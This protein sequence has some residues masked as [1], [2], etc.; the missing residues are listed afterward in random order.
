MQQAADY[1]TRSIPATGAI[2]AVLIYDALIP[3]GAGVT[4]EIQV[5][6]GAWETMD[7]DGATQ[8]GDGLVEYKFK[9][10]LSG[11]DLIKVRLTLTGTLSAR[12]MVLNV[13][14]MAVA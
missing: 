4:P 8:Q 5:D 1:Y 3:S 11:A 2:K 12:P 10:A 14:L 7:A 6:S 9:H 13:R